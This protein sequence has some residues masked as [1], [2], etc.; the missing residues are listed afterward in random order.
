MWLLAIMKSAQ[1]YIFL[2]FTPSLERWNY[3][4]EIQ[5]ERNEQNIENIPKI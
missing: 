3:R 1:G 5:K 2:H 4:L